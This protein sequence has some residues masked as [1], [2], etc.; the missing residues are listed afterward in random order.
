MNFFKRIEGMFR[1]GEKNKPESTGRA[2]TEG[3]ELSLPTKLEAYGLSRESTSSQ[4]ELVADRLMGQAG[5]GG[6]AGRAAVRKYNR[7]AELVFKEL[8]DQEDEEGT[9]M[10]HGLDESGRLISIHDEVLG[11]Y[12]EDPDLVYNIGMIE[13]DGK[14]QLRVR[15]KTVNQVL[16]GDTLT[17]Y[18][19][20]KNKQG[21]KARWPKKD[22]EVLGQ[23]GQYG[24]EVIYARV[25]VDGVYRAKLISE[26]AV[27][28]QGAIQQLNYM[29]GTAVVEQTGR[30]VDE[31][32]DSQGSAMSMQKYKV[33]NLRA[34]LLFLQN[35][36][37][38]IELAQHTQASG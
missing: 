19:V 14:G 32:A 12:P 38:E 8:G 27:E 9:R 2:E 13:A 25:K 5:R 4:I 24:P 30:M 33:S 1:G 29:A 20:K 11:L 15:S 6:E 21:R 22:F 28:L 36:N 31:G 7:L 18:E 34:K 17:Q 35:L 26:T 10:Q 3:A 23:E 37:K 16:N